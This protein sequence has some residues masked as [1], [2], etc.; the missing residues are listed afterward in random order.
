MA[1]LTPKTFEYAFPR[2][3]PQDWLDKATDIWNQGLRILE[4]KQQFDRKQKCLAVNAPDWGWALDVPV[5]LEMEKYNDIWGMTCRIGRDQRI[6]KTKSWDRFNIEFRPCCNI[7]PPHW[8]LEPPIDGYSAFSL[9]KP[10]TKLRGFDPG[11]L[12]SNLVQSLLGRLADSWK[13]YQKGQRGKPRYRGR[14]NPVDSL[15]YDGFR[16]HCKVGNDG[17]VTLMG[18][19][20]TVCHGIKSH[21]LPLMEQTYQYLL[22]NPTERVLKKAEKLGLD[23][24]ARFY[25]IPGFYSIHS[26]NGKTYL[27]LSGDFVDTT[28]TAKRPEIAITTGVQ[29]LW[30]DGTN[31]AGHY[32]TDQIEARIVRLQQVLAGKTFGSRNWQEIKEKISALQRKKAAQIKTHQHY[33]AQMLAGHTAI[34]VS[35][36]A[37]I[38]PAP[39]P[40]PDG[41]G[42]YLPNGAT[43]IAEHNRATATAATAQ[44]VAILTQ[45]AKY[46]GATIL[47]KR[48]KGGVVLNSPRSPQADFKE[49]KSVTEHGQSRKAQERGKSASSTPESQQP[50]KRKGRNRL[51][52]RAIG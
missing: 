51:R 47:D 7:I 40:I 19:P 17:S 8:L 44:F 13:A 15:T 20:P 35:H 16:H 4:W 41:H 18:M 36:E 25:S 49:P 12:H 52:E 23:A 32:P 27:Q 26:R 31:S 30:D 14:K 37:E 28:P 50:R 6:D 5:K 45:E 39:V 9:R 38:I 11:P 21:L 3:I 42:E 34:T 22:E 24:A 46:S 48:K 29:K 33:H 43:A 10:F 1:S 2:R